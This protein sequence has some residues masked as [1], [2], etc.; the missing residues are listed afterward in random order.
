MTE[1]MVEAIGIDGPAGSGKSTIARQVAERLGFTYID[2]GAMYRAVALQAFRL[3]VDL[4][5]EGAM[6]RIASETDINFDSTGTIIYLNNEDISAAIRTPEITGIT[7]YAARVTDVRH[8]LVARQ[9]EMARKRPVVMEGRDITTV[10][11]AQ[12]RWRIF[13]TASPE[14]RAERRMKDFAE[15][16]HTVSYSELLKEIIARDESDNSVGPMK[17]AQELA[18]AGRGIY[19]LDTS[20]LTQE[21]VIDKIVKYVKSH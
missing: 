21:E 12:A 11:L 6:A 5:D 18:R 20:Q 19:L 9:Q 3:G 2:T 1:N 14:V 16:G 8:C 17:E 13:L 7:K 4:E 15:R 10:V